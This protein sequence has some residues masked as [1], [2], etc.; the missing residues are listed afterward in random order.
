MSEPIKGIVTAEI[1]K[2]LAKYS[3]QLNNGKTPANAQSGPLGGQITQ[4]KGQ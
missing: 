3:D 1:T 4:N 2:A